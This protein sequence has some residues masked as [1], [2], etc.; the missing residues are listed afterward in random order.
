M[1]HDP[2]SSSALRE[3]LASEA[4]GGVILMIVAVLAMIVANS[5]LSEAYFHLL[6]AQTGPVLSDKLGPMTVHLWINDA[7]MAVFFLLVGLEI[8]REFVD[9]RLVT[10]QQRRLPFIAALGGMA[11]PAAVFL[12]VTAGSRDLAQGWAIP[13]ATDIAFAIGVMALIGSR[14][15]T[16]LKLFLTTV[17]IVDD[18]GAVVIIA[19]A[20]TASIKG[21][22][23]LSAAA[24]LGGMMTMNRAGVRHLAPYLIGFALL[25]FAVLVSGVHATIAGVLA[26][27]TVPVVGTPGRPDSPDSPLHRLEHRLHPWSAFLIVPLFGFAN[28]GISLTA[29]GPSTLLEP[30]PLGIAAGLFL[31][32]QLGIFSAIWL[33]VKL[34]ISQRPRGSTWVQVYGLAVLCGIG[35]TMSL[36]I[37]MLAYATSPEL[38]EEAK[39]GVMSGSLLSGLLGYLVLRFAKPAADAASAEAEIEKEIAEDGDVAAIETRTWS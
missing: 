9:G 18:M 32:K 6:H 20:Y 13:A 33:S 37:G 36:F 38:V 2:R 39:L 1:N 35:F 23:L 7:L 21:V 34:G 24:I 19:L 28:A 5:S 31:G 27:F 16:A 3:F 15:P 25:W 12:A 11:V 17:A 10:W 8:K 26:A 29:F 4:A 30:L 22:A 14:A